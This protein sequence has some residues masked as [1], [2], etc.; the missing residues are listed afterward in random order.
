M[1]DTSNVAKDQ[2]EKI[3]E[4]YDDDK[5]IREKKEKL[6]ALDDALYQ[7]LQ[8]IQLENDYL[9]MLKGKVAI[10]K[11]IYR[12][13]E[14]CSENDLNDKLIPVIEKFEKSSDTKKHFPDSIKK[15]VLKR[16]D[17]ECNVCKR[18]LN[19]VDYDHIDGNRS[20]N[21]V[22]NCQALC[23]NCHAEKTRREQIGK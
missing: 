23:P 7:K 13:Q 21:D 6:D 11:E 22:S 20:N 14:S 5:N 15:E 16:Q 9:E 12:N 10:F 4:N 19:V 8:E 3:K 1:K 17:Y 2:Y 18:L